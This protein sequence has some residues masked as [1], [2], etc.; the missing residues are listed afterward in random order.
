VGIA[1]VSTSGLFG[2]PTLYT[3][4]ERAIQYIPNPRYTI[5][6]VLVEPKAPSDIQRIKQQVS[7]LGYRAL[8]K[9]E[10]MQKTS[11]FYKYQTGVGINIVI[12]TVISFIVG[13]SISGQTFYTFI[14]ENLER[15]G[16]LKAIGARSRELV[17][18]ILFQAAFTSLTGYGLGVGLCTLLIWLARFRLPDYA[19]MVTYFNLSIAF[20]MVLLIAGI[21]SYIGVRK[22]LRIEPFEIFRG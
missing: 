11:D 17:A 14:L 2:I 13:L 4:Y 10:F 12:M 22:V 9:E 5:S 3:T 7:A 20:V 21:S 8:T 6:Y 1:K 19:A 16:A 15:F 18:M